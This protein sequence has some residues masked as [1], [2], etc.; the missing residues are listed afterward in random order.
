MQRFSNS[1]DEVENA[2]NTFLVY[3]IVVK[4]ITTFSVGFLKSC[5]CFLVTIIKSCLYYL[6]L[7][8]VFS[9]GV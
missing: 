5:F 3:L 7:F 4:L 6:L 9:Y 1:L 8:S 2:T